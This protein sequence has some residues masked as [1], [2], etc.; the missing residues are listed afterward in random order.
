MSNIINIT[1]KLS[2]ERP[3]IQ[4]GEVEY[5]VDN[6]MEAVLRYEEISNDEK[7]GANMLKAIEVALGKEATESI[8]VTER[9]H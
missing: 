7:T 4:I 8:K 5:E 9:F 1:D 6:S 2:T 3:K